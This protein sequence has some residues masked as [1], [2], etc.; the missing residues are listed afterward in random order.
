MKIPVKSLTPRSRTVLGLF[1]LPLLLVALP[2]TAADRELTYQRIEVR[3]TLNK[4]TS[5]DVVETQQVLWSGAWNGL[6]RNYKLT[7][8]ADVKILSVREN[9]QEYKRGSVET[10][11]GYIVEREPGHVHVKWRSRNVDA[12]PYNNDKTTF[13]V[14]YTLTG[15]IAQDAERD[16]LHWNPIISERTHP[17]KE[18]RVTLEMPEA[19]DQVNV[20]FYSRTPNAKWQIDEEN[21]RLIRF[22]ASNIPPEDEFQIKVSLPKGLLEE[23]PSRQRDILEEVLRILLW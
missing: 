23:G 18:A 17:L 10:K 19:T 1:L 11:G 13:H 22:S 7:R 2:A 15:A 5:I 9:D 4:D 20:V 21:R 16:V 14:R 8:A 12:P 3:M 6:Y